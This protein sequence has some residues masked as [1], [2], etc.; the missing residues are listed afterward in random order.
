VGASATAVLDD[1][2]SAYAPAPIGGTPAIPIAIDAGFWKD[3]IVDGNGPDLYSFDPNSDTV[4]QSVDG[5]PEITL[6]PKKLKDD[7]T[8]DGAGNFGL[9]HVGP[10]SGASAVSEQIE[11][12][13]S[14]EDFID[15]TGEPM[16]EFY[17]DDSPVG[18]NAT[19]YDV[20]GD[21]GLKAGLKAALEEKI[22]KVVAFFMYDTVIDDGANAVFHITGMRFGR[23]MEVDLTGSDKVFVIQPVPYYG[24]DILTS[25]GAPSTDR[26]IGTLQLVR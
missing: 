16:I 22:G 12:G 3:Q 2:F 5:M 14:P 19:S 21:P 7:E 9:L 11:N 1:R 26:L 20:L 4:Q 6:Y 15:L 24:Q 25:P 23:V 17:D 13:I 10:D 8:P 18:Y